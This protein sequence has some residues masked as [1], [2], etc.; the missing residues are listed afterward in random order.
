MEEADEEQDDDESE[1]SAEDGR[2]EDGHLRGEGGVDGYEPQRGCLRLP[3]G[4][5]GVAELAPAGGRRR[6]FAGF[7]GL[8]S[9]RQAACALG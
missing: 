8:F 9:P 4:A 3:L 5:L 7:V 2:A 1:K 6:S